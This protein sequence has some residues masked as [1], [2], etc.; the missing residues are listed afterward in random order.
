MK[1]IISFVLYTFLNVENPILCHDNLPELVA[2]MESQ[3]AR[4]IGVA[5]CIVPK[6]EIP[7]AALFVAPSIPLLPDLLKTAM[8]LNK[9]PT[10]ILQPSPSIVQIILPA[11][12]IIQPPTQQQSMQQDDASA[13]I[14]QSS[15]PVEQKPNLIDLLTTPQPQPQ[16]PPTTAA[17]IP[18]NMIK[19][20]E[21]QQQQD[22]PTILPFHQTNETLHEFVDIPVT[23]TAVIPTTNSQSTTVQ[24]NLSDTA[25]NSVYKQLSQVPQVI[26]TNSDRGQQFIEPVEDPPEMVHDQSVVTK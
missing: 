13:A 26:V 15:E 16:P 25:D 23:S 10:N 14:I 19:P 12:I 8:P 3:E 4:L 9:L 7:N 20:D 18:E 11:T 6:E 22:T 24:P 21:D 2:R 17:N 1:I 5:H